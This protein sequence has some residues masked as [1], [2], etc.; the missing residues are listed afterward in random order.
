VQLFEPPYLTP[1][2][3]RLAWAIALTIDVAQFLLG[4]S[5]LG[6]ELNEIL[7]GVAIAPYVAAHRI[8]PVTPSDIC[9]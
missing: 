4:P 9:P 6:P 5:R 8:P 3:V 2:R 1:S 7:D